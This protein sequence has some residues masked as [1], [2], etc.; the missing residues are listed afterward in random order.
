MD[1]KRKLIKVDER[2]EDEE[3]SG[4]ILQR[5]Y[6]VVQKISLG[7]RKNIL[8]RSGAQDMTRFSYI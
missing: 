5:M 8:L 4:K 7:K 1:E 6:R 2:P 3:H